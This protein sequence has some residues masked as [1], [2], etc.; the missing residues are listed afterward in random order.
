[1]EHVQRRDTLIWVPR[2]AFVCRCAL[3]RGMACGSDSG[4]RLGK[5]NC[6]HV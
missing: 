1:M 3:A 2:P 6:V 4:D 5:R